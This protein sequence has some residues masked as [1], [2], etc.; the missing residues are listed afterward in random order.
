[1]ATTSATAATA[2]VLLAVDAWFDVSTSAGPALGAATT[3]AGI[4]EIPL[5]VVCVV[6]AL[7]GQRAL[8]TA[9]DSRP[10]VD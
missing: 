4:I 1:V 3:L 10:A 6:L 2:A 8:V 5:A 7:R 9:D